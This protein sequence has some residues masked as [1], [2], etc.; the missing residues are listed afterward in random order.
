MIYMMAVFLDQ[1]PARE[2]EINV[3]LRKT[4][5]READPYEDLENFL[6]DSTRLMARNATMLPGLPCR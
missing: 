4:Q 3:K 2:S 6:A 5:A 1:L